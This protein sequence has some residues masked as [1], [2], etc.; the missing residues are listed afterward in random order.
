MSAVGRRSKRRWIIAATSAA[1]ITMLV[2][3]WF[4]A[5][6]KTQVSE[7]SAATKPAT[8]SL[9]RVPTGEAALLDPT[10]LFLP[11]EWNTARKEVKLPESRG[12]FAGYD[13]KWRFDVSELKLGLP[14]PVRV[15]ANAAEALLI[16]APG[17][18]FGGFGR[19][20]AVMEPLIGRGAFI[21]VVAVGSGRRILAEALTAARAPGGGGWQPLEFLAAVDAAGLV[22]LDLTARS[23]LEE[24]DVYFTRY[25]A[26]TLRIG[27][28]LAPGFYR[29]CVGP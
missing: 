1:A 27:A 16:P 2:A 18:P 13:A 14:T 28:R 8:V 7:T 17:A 29:I 12:A 24:V 6:V 22:S 21:E 25:L 26:Q 23:G 9:T 11:T 10:P 3:S 5:P 15:S 20:D 4:R 19:S